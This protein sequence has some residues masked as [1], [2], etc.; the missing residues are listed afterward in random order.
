MSADNKMH[1]YVVSCFLSIILLLLPS[2]FHIQIFYWRYFTPPTLSEQIP[3][4]CNKMIYFLRFCAFSTIWNSFHSWRPFGVRSFRTFSHNQK[5]IFGLWWMHKNWNMT[6]FMASSVRYYRHYLLQ[7]C[8][9]F[10]YTCTVSIP[11]PWFFLKSVALE[12]SLYHYPLH[13]R[14]TY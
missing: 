4:S 2:I 3:N 14:Q 12:Q 1:C 8:M 5:V 6:G 10:I 11:F 9:Y 13:V 7:S